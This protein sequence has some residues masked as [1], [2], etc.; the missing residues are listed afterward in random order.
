MEIAKSI[1]FFIITGIAELGG[2]YLIWLWIREGKSAWYALAGVAVLF[3]YGMLP[4]LQL[5]NFGRVQAAYS[6]I[7]M[8]IALFWGWGI[9]KIAPDRFDIIGAVIALFGMGV[10]MY[11]PR[12]ITP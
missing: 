2:A 8:L 11:A 1:F 12:S 10:I 3:I 9:D 5:A 7:F 4:T 6:G